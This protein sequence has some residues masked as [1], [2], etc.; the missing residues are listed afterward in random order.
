MSATTIVLVVAATEA[1]VALAIA[2]VPKYESDAE[3]Y[4]HFRSK[5]SP[6]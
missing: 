6:N 5:D 2:A 4:T 1:L 3:K